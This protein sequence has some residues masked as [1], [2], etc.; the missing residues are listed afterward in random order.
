MTFNREV[1]FHEKTPSN[2]HCGKPLNSPSW[3]FEQFLTFFVKST[4]QR[5]SLVKMAKIELQNR[6]DLS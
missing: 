6:A 5:F 2:A 3:H 1:Q 4:Q